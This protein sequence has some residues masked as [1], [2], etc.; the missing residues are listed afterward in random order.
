MNNLNELTIILYTHYSYKD[1]F[2]IAISLHETYSSNINIVIFSNKNMNEKYMNIIYS[3]E[4]TYPERLSYCLNN[5]PSQYKYIILSHDW[6]FIY[7]HINYNKIDN[8]ISLMKSKN[9]DQVR[10]LNACS[11]S[12]C[13]L[14]ENNTYTIGSDGLLFSLQPTLWS[15][16]VLKKITTENSQYVYKNIELGI[17]EYMRQFNNC[18]YYE[19][20]ANFK[21]SGHCKSNIY[22]HIHTLRHGEWIIHENENYIIDIIEKFN[23][24]VNIRGIHQC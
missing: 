8:L 18:F 1:I 2:D 21:N 5:L 10:L 20:E 9:I 4:M 24:D 19:G 17:Q 12:N 23:I 16:N 7:D 3:D 13:L 15:I 11:G 14:I 22:P 6:V